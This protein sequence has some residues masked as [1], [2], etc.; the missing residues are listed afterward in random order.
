LF[1]LKLVSTGVQPPVGSCSSIAIDGIADTA[2]R[3]GRDPSEFG[4]AYTV[5]LELDLS[6][7][8][9]DLERPRY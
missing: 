5:A 1:S 8:G 2:Q 9:S 4:Y 7:P 3:A 6:G